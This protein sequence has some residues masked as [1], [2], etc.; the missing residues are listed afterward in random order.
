LLLLSRQLLLLD[1]N[2]SHV[3]EKFRVNLLLLLKIEDLI[4]KDGWI[5][6]NVLAKW[7]WSCLILFGHLWVAWHVPFVQGSELP[8]LSFSAFSFPPVDSFGFFFAKVAVAVSNPAPLT[9]H[10]HSLNT[11]VI[12]IEQNGSTFPLFC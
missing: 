8:I 9:A 4:S 3:A 1:N 5:E 6:A 2:V 10:L 11:A 7:S 12:S